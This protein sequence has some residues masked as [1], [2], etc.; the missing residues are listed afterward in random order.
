MIPHGTFFEGGVPDGFKLAVTPSEGYVI[1]DIDMHG[2]T[3]G[4]E[5]IPKHLSKE[6]SN[7]LNYHTKNDG[8]HC[9]FKYTGDS[10]LANKTS[11]LGIDLRTHKGYVIYYPDNDIREQ[12]HLVKDSSKELNTWLES[13]FGFKKNN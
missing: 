8:M 9:W 13:L 6:L 7:T 10:I 1:I 11:N 5:S 4:F 3:N 12:M 2:D